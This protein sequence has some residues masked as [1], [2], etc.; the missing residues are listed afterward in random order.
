MT[1]LYGERRTIPHATTSRMLHLCQ[2]ISQLSNSG[3]LEPFNPHHR[4]IMFPWRIPRHVSTT[5]PAQQKGHI[6]CN[7]APP[8]K[9]IYMCEHKLTPPRGRTWRRR[10]WGQRSLGRMPEYPKAP[11]SRRCTF[12]LFSR[13]PSPTFCSSSAWRVACRQ[14]M[15]GDQKRCDRRSK[16][17]ESMSNLT[18]RTGKLNMTNGQ[19]NMTEG[20]NSQERAPSQTWL[21]CIQ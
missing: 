10:S 3:Q 19:A 21:R 9:Y 5:E 6:I 15:R 14:N 7:P 4:R 8:K 18:W 12:E 17:H 13:P 20:R 16:Q 2:A 11:L 1:G